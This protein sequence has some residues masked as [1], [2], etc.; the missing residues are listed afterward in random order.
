MWHYNYWLLWHL[1]VCSVSNAARQQCVF[2]IQASEFVPDRGDLAGEPGAGVLRGAVH[3]WGGPRVLWR[4][5]KDG[6]ISLAPSLSWLTQ[7]TKTLVLLLYRKSS[8]QVTMVRLAA[9]SNKSQVIDKLMFGMGSVPHRR[10]S[11]RAE[12]MPPR[13]K[14]HRQEGGVQLLLRD[15]LLR[16]NLWAGNP[17]TNPN[18]ITAQTRWA[19]VLAPPPKAWFRRIE[20]KTKIV[21]DFDYCEISI[22]GSP[23]GYSQCPTDGP[24]ACQQVCTALYH[25]FRCSC[26]PGFKLQSDKRSCLPD[27]LIYQY[28]DIYPFVQT[29]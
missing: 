7:N 5:S 21:S 12:P 18:C 3:L 19:D 26:M 9:S 16:K 25:N 15:P 4:H 6:G 27:G 11:V 22:P 10:E 1:N 17:K 8:G 29:G 24:T 14:L 23:S 28:S 20:W 13:R 2:A